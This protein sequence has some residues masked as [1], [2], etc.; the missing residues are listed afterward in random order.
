MAY[1]GMDNTYGT[2]FIYTISPDGG[3]EQRFFAARSGE[4]FR[5]LTWG[6]THLLFVSNFTGAHEI[7][8]LN[9]DGSGPFQLT[10]DKREN[11]S[12]AWNPDGKTFAYYSKQADNS[13]QIMIANSDGTGA[14]KLTTPAT[15]GRRCG[16]PMAITSR[17]VQ[18][19]A[20]GWQ[21]G[22]WTRP[23]G[24]RKCSPINS[25]RTDNCPGRGGN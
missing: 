4:S 21:S 9:S 5:G 11:G 14:K 18:H 10:T 16:R 1:V 19:A 23:A 7:W 17:S 20:V 15:T 2:Q 22:S 8:R 12:P 25:A 24:I 6:K 13:Y 3:T